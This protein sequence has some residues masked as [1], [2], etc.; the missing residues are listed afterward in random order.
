MCII[1][2][3]FLPEL[4]LNSAVISCIPTSDCTF[5]FHVQLNFPTRRSSDLTIVP[6]P[7]VITTSSLPNGTVG[8]AYSQT[9]NARRG[10]RGYHWTRTG[11]HP[12]GLSLN[13][14]VISGIP[15]AA[16]TFNF[17]VKV[18]ATVAK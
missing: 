15:T 10:T 11:T 1:T 17:D 8:V 5:N 18:N 2:C 6:A 7:L 12:T 13:E 4:F 9:L 14:G 3:K 16:G